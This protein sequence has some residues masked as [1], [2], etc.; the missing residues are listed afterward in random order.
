MQDNR[1]QYVQHTCNFHGMEQ[2]N[3][4]HVHT[5]SPLQKGKKKRKMNVPSTGKYFK[6]RLFFTELT[7]FISIQCYILHTEMDFNEQK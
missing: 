4:D 7:P 3:I 1:W 6:G 2:T 5:N